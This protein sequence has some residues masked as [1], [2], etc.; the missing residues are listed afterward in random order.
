MSDFL[1]ENDSDSSLQ[2]ELSRRGFFKWSALLA[3][4]MA[5]AGASA[6]ALSPLD[7]RGTSKNAAHRPDR[8]VR[9]GCPRIT[10]EASAC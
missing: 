2:E 8:V 1:F 6:Q 4:A 5:G 3:S 10:A 7:K 9:V